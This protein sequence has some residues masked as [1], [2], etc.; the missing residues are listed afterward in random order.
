[1]SALYLSFASIKKKILQLISRYEKI[2]SKY[3]SCFPGIDTNL[4]HIFEAFS[5]N[6]KK[7]LSFFPTYGMIDVYSRIYKLKI[8]KVPEKEISQFLNKKII[9]TAAFIY[10]AIPNQPSGKIVS[11]Q[12]MIKILKIANKF[13]KII[14]IDEAY[15]DFSD[16]KSLA[17]FVRKFK[18][19]IVLKT[20][21]KNV[22]IAGLRFS[23]MLS[24]PNLSKIINAFRPPYDISH[25]SIKAAKYF[26]KNKKI[27]K[28][29]LSEIKKSKR[30]VI[31]I[32]LKKNFYLQ[33]TKANF[34]YV[35]FKKSQCIKIVRFLKRKK[36]L[37]KHLSNTN[38]YKNS[39]RVSYGSIK[40]MR[41][42]FKI[43]Q[44]A[45]KIK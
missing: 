38:N 4:K 5:F 20:L 7:F 39:I 28:D 44:Q 45:R 26:F 24:N 29:Y 25:F 30:F 36:I 41:F 10:F 31:D 23:Y 27:L 13:K 11:Y 32:C 42:F 1:M 37:I 33:E 2:N 3:I 9:K 18:N 35:Y 16:Q 19:L 6:E 8:I 34:F 14:I 43:L 21:S 15:L 17:P 40:Q 12:Q 22:G